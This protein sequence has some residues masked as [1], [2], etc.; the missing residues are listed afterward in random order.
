MCQLTVYDPRFIDRTFKLVDGRV[1][2]SIGSDVV[3]FES[4]DYSTYTNSEVL[5]KLL[6]SLVLEC[7]VSKIGV[8][9]PDTNMISS[10]EWADDRSISQQLGFAIIDVALLDRLIERFDKAA[11]YGVWD[12]YG[13]P[14]GFQGFDRLQT[15]PEILTDFERFQ[16]VVEVDLDGILMGYARPIYSQ[17]DRLIEELR[18]VC[19]IEK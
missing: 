5:S 16:F 9:T 13:L 3:F 14:T 2:S 7:P 8:R 17:F 15:F 1:W 19:G 11:D 10:L 18:R 4:D 12:F 6:T